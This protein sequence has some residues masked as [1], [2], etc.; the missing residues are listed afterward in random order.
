MKALFVLFTLAIS[1][2]SAADS[3]KDMKTALNPKAFSVSGPPSYD[4]CLMAYRRPND[5]PF[6][7][8]VPTDEK[9]T[10]PSEFDVSLES[11]PITRAGHEF[12]G[13]LKIRATLTNKDGV[14]TVVEAVHVDDGPGAFNPIEIDNRKWAFNMAPVRA[15]IVRTKS[16]GEQLLKTELC[17]GIRQSVG[18]QNRTSEFEACNPPPRG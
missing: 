15:T 7:F 12:K 18:F 4:G 3:T 8:P 6:Y 11:N 17:M 2:V 5:L 10:C 9:G 13:A 1:D 16:N 14:R